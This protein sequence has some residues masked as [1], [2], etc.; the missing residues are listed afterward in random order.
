MVH[1]LPFLNFSLPLKT[2]NLLV[3]GAPLWKRSRRAAARP[4]DTL[5]GIGRWFVHLGKK[6]AVRSEHKY[7]SHE[8]KDTDYPKRGDLPG[9]NR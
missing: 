2:E 4:A 6:V 8:G 7:F 3:D 9:A 1:M 5:N